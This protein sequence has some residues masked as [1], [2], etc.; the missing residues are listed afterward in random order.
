MNKVKLFQKQPSLI[1]ITK[2]SMTES[3]KLYGVAGN[4]RIFEQRL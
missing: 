4:D 1:E 2:V 3:E